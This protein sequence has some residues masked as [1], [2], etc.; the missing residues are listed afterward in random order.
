MDRAVF[1][2]NKVI[3]FGI[4]GIVVIGMTV[5]YFNIHFP[6]FI[7]P[8]VY[9]IVIF[10]AI[11]TLKTKV[12]IEDGMLRYEK[13]FGGEEVELKHVA[14]IVVREVETIVDNHKNDPS[15]HSL[16]DRNVDVKFGNIRINDGP[17]VDQERK[18][19]KIV[20]VID[21]MGRTMFSFPAGV[22]RF[23]ERKRFREAIQHVNPNIHVF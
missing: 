15:R 19:E 5:A 2:S 21:E 16:D 18:V 9:V 3:L 23:T 10:I 20:Y 22:I 4:L 11:T 7:L 12:V 17:R 8:I 13:L 14:Q 6:V 1:Q